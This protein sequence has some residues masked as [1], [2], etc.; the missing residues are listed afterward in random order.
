MD[1]S[2]WL[3]KYGDV[4]FLTSYDQ[5]CSA[6]CSYFHFMLY[7]YHITRAF[8]DFLEQDFNHAEYILC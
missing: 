7:D 5:L 4:L 3:E 6:N 1:V 8:A 2:N